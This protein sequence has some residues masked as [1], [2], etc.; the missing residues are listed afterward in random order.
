VC[1]EQRGHLSAETQVA[2]TGGIQKPLARGRLTIERR[3][4]KLLDPAPALGGGT[5]HASP[6]SRLSQARAMVQSRFTVAGDVPNAS[7][8]S[9][10]LIPPKKRHSTTRP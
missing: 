1:R 3:R 2:G 5:R 6:S 4:E 9:S 8:V 10:T 7:A